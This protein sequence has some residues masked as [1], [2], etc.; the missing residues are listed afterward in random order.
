MSIGGV[1]QGGQSSGT[2]APPQ[3]Y[4]PG[5][6]GDTKRAD[7]GG[8]PRHRLGT[9]AL[10]VALQQLRRYLGKSSWSRYELKSSSG[11]DAGLCTAPKKVL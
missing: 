2:A 4:L 11:H 7:G 10:A 8:A 9:G 1:H 3:Q 5:E 6:G